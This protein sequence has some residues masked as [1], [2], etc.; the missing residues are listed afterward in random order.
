[1][2]TDIEAKRANRDGFLEVATGVCRDCR[3]WFCWLAR[4]PLEPLVSVDANTSGSGRQRSDCT[5]ANDYPRGMSRYA[6]SER[7]YPNIRP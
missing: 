3:S 2:A 1:M 6:I 4:G 7:G 5:V